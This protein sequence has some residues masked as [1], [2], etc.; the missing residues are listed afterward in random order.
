MKEERGSPT[1]RKRGGGGG[2]PRTRFQKPIPTL[3]STLS[4]FF[5]IH[6]RKE[7]RGKGRSEKGDFM[8]H[9]ELTLGEK[10]MKLYYPPTVFF[11]NFL[12]IFFYS[13]LYGR[14]WSGIIR[15]NMQKSPSSFCGHGDGRTDVGS[16]IWKLFLSLLVFVCEPFLA[17]I[18]LLPSAKVQHEVGQAR[19]EVPL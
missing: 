13:P 12:E 11:Q 10:K 5:G 2:D 14:T 8:G 3:L 1:L 6:P 9:H 15:P 18:Y 4:S 19:L 7:G 17:P 16:S